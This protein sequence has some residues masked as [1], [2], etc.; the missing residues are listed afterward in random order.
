M[1]K[2]Q[3]S[4][5]V[6]LRKRGWHRKATPANYAKS[7]VIEAAEL[8]ELMQWQEPS[9]KELKKDKKRYQK[10][11]HELADIM[12]YCLDF[13]VMMGWDAEKIVKDKMAY[14]DKKYPVKAVKNNSKNYYRLKEKFR[15]GK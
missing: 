2:L 9:A 5:R 12:I 8:L 11:R 10:A 3:N 4:I 15:T 14:N 13:A 6:F 1:N 7:I